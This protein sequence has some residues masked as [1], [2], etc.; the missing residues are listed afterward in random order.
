MMMGRLH[1]SA[2]KSLQHD[3]SRMDGRKSEILRVLELLQLIRFYK[4]CHHEAIRELHRATYNKKAVTKHGQKY[5]TGFAQL[6]GAADTA[7]FNSTDCAFIVYNAFRKMGMTPLQA[8]QS[9]GIIGGDDGVTPDVDLDI[10][11]ACAQEVG[12]SMTCD[13]IMRG[14]FGVTFL[15]RMYGPD[16]WFGD[17]NSV[18][19]IIRTMSKFHTTV[20]LPANVTPLQKFKEKVLSASFSDSQTPVFGPFLQKALALIREAEIASMS[21]ENARLV[22]H[23]NARYS[24][25]DQYPN[26]VDPNGW[27]FDYVQYECDRVLFKINMFNW[28]VANCLTVNELMFD[29]GRCYD[30]PVA[31]ELP[32]DQSVVVDG[33][34][35]FPKMKEEENPVPL[36]IPVEVG[37]PVSKLVPP[38]LA[39]PPPLQGVC[40]NASCPFGKL[41]KCLNMPPKTCHVK[42]GKCDN[43][44]CS[45]AKYD[46]C[47]LAGKAGACAKRR[48]KSKKGTGQ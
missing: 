41:G 30:L 43:P 14:T 21:D 24:L 20:H 29:R 9:I 42:V 11:A 27:A 35:Y 33:E 18:C 7:V 16:I 32:K 17:I 4:H 31:M 1:I 10:L 40:G 45:F 6:S 23:W 13:V 5:D 8:W 36:V 19:D 37:K 39:K 28:E 26:N 22:L 38:V 12:Q 3:L 15:A 48:V 46:M 34:P 47:N 2:Q 25:E 44:L